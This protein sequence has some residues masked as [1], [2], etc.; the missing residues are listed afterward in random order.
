M[1]AAP[2]ALLSLRQRARARPSLSAALVLAMRALVLAV[3]LVAASASG[4]RKKCD[5]GLKGDFQ[6]ETCA[7][8]CKVTQ[9]CMRCSL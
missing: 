1:P 7:S 4:D 9:V 8:F 6:Y 2:V 5:S 3:C